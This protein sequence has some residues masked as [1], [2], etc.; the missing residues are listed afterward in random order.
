MEEG[1]DGEMHP[2][3]RK[4]VKRA[5]GRRA[6]PE[7]INVD[8][9]TTTMFDLATAR[10][11]LA[12]RVSERGKELTRK[13][14]QKRLQR[15]AARQRMRDRAAR[16]KRGESVS[17]DD[18]ADQDPAANADGKRSATTSRRG[19]PTPS[20][21]SRRST[22]GPRQG[23]PALLDAVAAAMGR[24][25]IDLMDKLAGKENDNVTVAGSDD[26]DEDGYGELVET[27]YAP[28]MRIVDG[29][30]VIDEASLE[31]DRAAR[32]RSLPRFSSSESMD[33]ALTSPC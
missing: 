8:P 26:E 19:S 18:E 20:N 4:K 23:S 28:Q 33:Q 6:S 13:V 31:V 25:D 5:K 17:D 14:E 9:A 27:E 15:K 24:G 32:V 11:T 30:L 1:S 22:P 7:R 3:R 29:E 2:Q 16:K 12:G 10:D 21:G